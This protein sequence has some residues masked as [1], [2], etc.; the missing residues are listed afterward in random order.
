MVWEKAIFLYSE[1]WHRGE[2]ENM[3]QIDI[4]ST[5][6]MSTTEKGRILENL[7][8]KLLRI[9]QIMNRVLRTFCECL[10]AAIDRGNSCSEVVTLM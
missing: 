1:L 10:F 7:A 9:Q 3:I 5:T 6:E 4:G 2:I 8:A